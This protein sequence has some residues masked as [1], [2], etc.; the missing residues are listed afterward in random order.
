MHCVIFITASNK[1]E[2]EHITAELL[3]N[4]LVACVNLVDNITS[5]F[6]WEG[7]IDKAGEVLL[8]AK[9]KKTK[10]S[11]IIKLVKSLHSYEVPEIIALP[12]IAGEKKYLNWINESLR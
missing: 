6:W 10:I 4:K 5:F 2:A 1:I 7:K 9:S 3:K 8:V 11:K 12:I